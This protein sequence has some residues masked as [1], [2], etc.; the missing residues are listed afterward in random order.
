MNI[1]IVNGVEYHDGY[2]IA[3]RNISI[4]EGKL[5][6]VA[7]L[8]GLGEKQSEALKSEIRSILWG[9]GFMKYGI[10]ITSDE[11]AEF[12]AKKK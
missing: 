8:L 11:I 12:R 9:R 6:T 4:I 10:H 2:F 7:E 5:L 3:E 1:K